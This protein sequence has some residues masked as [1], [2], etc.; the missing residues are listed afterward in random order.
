MAAGDPGQSCNI[1]IRPS[2]NP[3]SPVFQA[4]KRAEKDGFLDNSNY[5][6]NSPTFHLRKLDYLT[7]GQNNPI[8]Q[9]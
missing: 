6:R 5:E 9:F 8:K 2:I 1:S 3:I 7:V 4:L